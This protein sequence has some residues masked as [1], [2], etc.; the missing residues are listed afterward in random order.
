M[1]ML[2]SEYLGISLFTKI[3]YD[4]PNSNSRYTDKYFAQVYGGFLCTYLF[5]QVNFDFNMI[6]LFLFHYSKYN[7]QIEFINTENFVIL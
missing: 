1:L 3:S 5:L 7:T 4:N 2:Q 6:F